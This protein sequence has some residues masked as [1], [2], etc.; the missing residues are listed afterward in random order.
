MT[1]TPRTPRGENLLRYQ[2]ATFTLRFLQHF[3]SRRLLLIVVTHFPKPRENV[4]PA[5]SQKVNHLSSAPEY[6]FR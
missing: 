2:H 1:R 6:S 5:N 4:V 3:A